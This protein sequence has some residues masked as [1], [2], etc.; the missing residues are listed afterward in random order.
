M[1]KEKS[2]ELSAVRRTAPQEVQDALGN[3]IGGFSSWYSRFQLF[4]GW[5]FQNSE[6]LNREVAMVASYMLSKDAYSNPKDG[7]APATQ[8]QLVNRAALS[9]EEINGPAIAEHGPGWMQDGWGKVLGTFKKYAWHMTIAQW[10]MARNALV[11]MEAVE[12]NT[13]KNFGLPPGMPSPTYIARRQILGILVPAFALA[14]VHGL[15]YYGG[16]SMIYTLLADDEDEEFDLFVRRNVGDIG[17]NGVLSHLTGA[18]IMS[19]TGFYG[20]TPFERPLGGDYRASQIGP[21]A[22]LFETVMGPVYSATVGKADRAIKI[23]DE[24]RPGA[25]RNGIMALLPTGFNNVNKAFNMA[26]EGVV[27]KR[28][29]RLV[30]TNAYDVAMQMFGFVPMD[31]ASARQIN[32]FVHQEYRR[33]NIVRSRL[34]QKLFAARLSGDRD[35]YR[36]LMEEVNEFNRREDVRAFGLAW[37]P[38]G[39]SQSMRTRMRYVTER[40]AISESAS[41]PID[42]IRDIIRYYG[43]R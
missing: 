17:F 12:R 36:E 35:T 41:I 13:D 10:T 22:H 33:V 43:L 6:R 14:G 11:S 28:G 24:G 23:F 25:V 4:G 31:V 5:F 3:G 15:P 38:S 9:V 7:S 16:A 18:S 27:D 8:N 34:A 21:T 40:E 30:E 19:R 39:L 42:R 20:H 37:T 26:V 29:V 1:L 2:L 32:N